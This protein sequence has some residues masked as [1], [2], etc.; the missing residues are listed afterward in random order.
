MTATGAGD[1]FEERGPSVP[2][3]TGH[4]PGRPAVTVARLL[5]TATW[6]HQGAWAKLAGRQPW[7]TE[8]VARLPGVGPDRAR[9]ATALLGVGEVALAA[10]TFTGRGPRAN[11]AVQVGTLVGAKLTGRVLT[12]RWQPDARHATL[13]TTLIV[14]CAA[15][16]A[17]TPVRHATAGHDHTTVRARDGRPTTA[18]RI[19]TRGTR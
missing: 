5:A 19:T 11:A 9:P 8:V 16:T 1:T 2:R 4:G 13:T 18:D 7:Q 17:G 10:W 14:A 12:G 6:A 15:V 3:R